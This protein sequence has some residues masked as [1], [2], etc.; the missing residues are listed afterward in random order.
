MKTVIAIV[1]WATLT[2]ASKSPRD[3]ETEVLSYVENRISGV[4][5]NPIYGRSGGGLACYDKY[6][7][8][9]NA[10]TENSKKD[11]QICV[12][13]ASTQRNDELNKVQSQAA[14]L[15]KQMEAVQDILR[16]CSNQ[17]DVLEYLNCIKD[18][19][20]VLQISME[21]MTSSATT[22]SNGLTSAYINI[23]KAEDRCTKTVLDKVKAD[24][25]ALTGALQ[26]C[27]MNGFDNPEP[28]T[29][30]DLG[31]STS[32]PMTTSTELVTTTPPKF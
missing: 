2:L 27:L 16:D 15:N 17:K 23:D 11:T 22:L 28:T 19:S 12:D 29:T 1:F 8:L 5:R 32:T 26:S 4:L 21:Q 31:P 13:R 24:T 3:V 20:Q 9:I 25:D 10:A 6:I 14:I 18:N 7:P 30:P